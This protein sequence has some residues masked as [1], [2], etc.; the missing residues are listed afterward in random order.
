MEA[1]I[2]MVA[3]LVDVGIQSMFSQC[4]YGICENVHKY[5]QQ[6]EKNCGLIMNL[7]MGCFRIDKTIKI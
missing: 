2:Q 7:K 5:L 3:C 6:R 1:A 4:L